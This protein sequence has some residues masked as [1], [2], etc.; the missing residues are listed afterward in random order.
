M[1]L[2]TLDNWQKQINTTGQKICC[3]CKQSK[4]LS[5]FP[6]HGT[7]ADGK[8]G[9]CV[10]CTSEMARERYKKKMEVKEG[11]FNPNEPMF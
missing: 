3:R 7:N 10:P 11:F 5:E 6:K 2:I 8:S 4:P 1:S 9:Y